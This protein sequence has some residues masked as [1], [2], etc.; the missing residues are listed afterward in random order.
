MGT[1]KEIY[2]LLSLSV[3]WV[4]LANAGDDTAKKISN[5]IR[6]NK[7]SEK[8]FHA[9]LNQCIEINCYEMVRLK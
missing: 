5:N 8:E 3:I 1:I 6:D 4:S 2:I 7:S 9:K